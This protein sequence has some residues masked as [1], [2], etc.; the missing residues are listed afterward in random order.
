MSNS[1]SSEPSSEGGPRWAP[2][3]QRSS[4]W[5]ESSL[6]REPCLTRGLWALPLCIPGALCF[7]ELGTMIT[8]S[9]GEY[10]YLMEAYGPI[11]AYLFSWVSL[12]VMKPSSF[13][14]ICLSFSEYVC[15]PFYVGCKPPVIVVKCLAAAAICE[16]P[17]PGR[18]QKRP[19]TEGV[20]GPRPPLLPSELESLARG[21]AG[22][23]VSLCATC[24]CRTLGTPR[25]MGAAGRGAAGCPAGQ[26]H[27]SGPSFFSQHGGTCL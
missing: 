19:G 2:P 20:R 23:G 6:G 14:I 27:G 12:M 16:Y 7:A 9:G 21:Q 26:S 8:K 17:S 3:Y 18:G 25:P 13:A 4:W 1:W 15:A 11:P 10:P 24:G 5:E 22:P